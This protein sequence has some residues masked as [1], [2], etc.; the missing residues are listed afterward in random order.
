MAMLSWDASCSVK[1]VR[2]DADHQKLF[3]LVKTL[4]EAMSA[5]KGAVMVEKIVKELSGFTQDHFATEESM[6]E[7]THYPELP[8]HRLEHQELLKRLEQFQQEIAAGRFVSSVP[9]AD[10]LNDWLVNHTKLTDQKY[11]EH[12]N[13]NGIF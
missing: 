7:R 6:M 9:V 13:A 3:A 11:S 12:L 2:L 5:G 4:R 8:S 10:F 1:V